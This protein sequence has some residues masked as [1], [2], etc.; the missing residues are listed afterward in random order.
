MLGCN[1][2]NKHA[3]FV[4]GQKFITIKD[5]INKDCE[6]YRR[7]DLLKLMC[8]LKQYFYSSKQGKAGEV[9]R[10][11][12]NSVIDNIC[13]HTGNEKPTDLDANEN[14]VSVDDDVMINMLVIL[15]NSVL[16]L[17]Y[18][19]API[20]NKFICLLPVCNYTSEIWDN[21]VSHMHAEHPLMEINKKKSIHDA[22]VLWPYMHDRDKNHAARANFPTERE[23]AKSMQKFCHTNLYN[24]K[25]H[26]YIMENFIIPKYKIK[27]G[28]EEFFFGSM[29]DFI[30]KN[31]INIH[32]TPVPDNG[33][34]LVKMLARIRINN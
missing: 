18:Q 10:L 14:H 21:I 31:K 4:D 20:P 2:K 24:C 16:N 29:D 13:L 1:D 23:L 28:F 17:N 11:F 15:D 27:G 25:T 30:R 12:L 19:E 8:K 3:G 5:E 34:S 32:C 22:T 26:M 7:R 33:E 6:L 9:K